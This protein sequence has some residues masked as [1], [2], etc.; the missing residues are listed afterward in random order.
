[1]RP[2]TT[3][4]AMTAPTLEPESQMLVAKARSLVGNQVATTLAAVLGAGLSPTPS[5][6]RS[7]RRDQKPRASPVSAV[8]IDHHT[9]A[10]KKERRGP[11]LS[12]YQ[13]ATSWQA[14]YAQKN[15][16]KTSP[17]CVAVRWK[18]SPMNGSATLR[19]ARSR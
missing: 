17:C 3:G 6:K 1:M 15:A 5:R 14:S 13:P 9:A 11:T 8:K 12:T 16:A 18:S 4:S 7:V 2:V 19:L 10:R